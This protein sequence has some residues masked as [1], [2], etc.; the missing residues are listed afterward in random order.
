MRIIGR[1]RNVN[2]ISIFKSLVLIFTGYSNL[3]SL[4]SFLITY[5]LPYPV[6]LFLQCLV[7]F[8]PHLL[9][10]KDKHKQDPKEE[11]HCP[12]HISG[13]GIQAKTLN[14]LYALIALMAVFHFLPL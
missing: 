10:Y 2:K 8:Y 7:L 6:D 3:K 4:I 5:T 1:V 14:V 11:D 12:F 9:L 13:T